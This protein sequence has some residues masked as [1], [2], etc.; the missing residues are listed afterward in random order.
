MFR[1]TRLRMAQLMQEEGKYKRALEFY[2]EVCYIDLN[3]PQ[4]H[5][6]FTPELLKDYPNFDPKESFLASGV[7]Y[8]TSSLIKELSL[9]ESEAK[10]MFFEHNG[11]AVSGFRLPVSLDQAWT[12]LG[13]ELTF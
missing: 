4:N 3:G 8:E 11:R 7:L 13:P 2:L 6:G 9:T 12:K 10:T 1:N 5:E